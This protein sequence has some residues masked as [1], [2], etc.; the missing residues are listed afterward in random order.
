MG[1]LH[2][3]LSGWRYPSK[4]YRE[5]SNNIINQFDLDKSTGNLDDNIDNIII[6]KKFIKN[7]EIQI[8]L[9]NVDKKL[10]DHIGICLTVIE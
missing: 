3:S 5:N 6:S 1:D 10:S 9:F 8:E 7:R 4:Q 2:I